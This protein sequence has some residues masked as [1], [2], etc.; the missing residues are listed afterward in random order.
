MSK[1][2]VTSP[3]LVDELIRKRKGCNEVAKNSRSEH[4]SFIS[5]LAVFHRFTSSQFTIIRSLSSPCSSKPFRLSIRLAFCCGNGSTIAGTFSDHLKPL[6]IIQRKQWKDILDI[7]CGVPSFYEAVF[8]C[9][10][11]NHHTLNHSLRLKSVRE[12]N[13]VRHLAA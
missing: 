5:A 13:E 8:D 4:L 10:L 12:F 2:P 9:P 6:H 1:G 3:W 7:E 11:L